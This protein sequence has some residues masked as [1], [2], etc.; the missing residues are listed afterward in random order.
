MPLP[1][2]FFVCQ[3]SNLPRQTKMTKQIAAVWSD[4][5]VENYVAREKIGNRR[6]DFC[7]GRQDQKT[8][9]ILSETELDRAAKHSLRFNA[10]EFAFSNLSSVRQFCARKRERN[11]VANFVISRAANDLALRP[12]C[13][14]HFAN[15]KT[16]GI[17]MS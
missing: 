1:Y 3:S 10:A 16:V 13:V 5:D 14:I 9:R 2:N 4:L 6:P 7:F 17:R 8:G 15:G 11:F 12:A